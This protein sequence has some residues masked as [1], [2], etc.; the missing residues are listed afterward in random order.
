MARGVEG[1]VAF[2][3]HDPAQ[4]GGRG[5]APCGDSWTGQEVS[6]DACLH[7]CTF[8]L[9]QPALCSGG[10]HY[11]RPRD[12]GPDLA[13][14]RAGWPGLARSTHHRFLRAAAPSWAVRDG[15]PA[16]RSCALHFPAP[17][18][19]EAGMRQ[20]QWRLRLFVVLEVETPKMLNQI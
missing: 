6:G 9:G 16:A 19:A 2:V 14:A 11:P 15:L 4:G 20:A 12:R 3:G 13:L 1:K 5:E 18:E 7:V 10:L 17:R 8:S